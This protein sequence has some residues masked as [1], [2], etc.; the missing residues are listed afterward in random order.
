MEFITTVDTFTYPMNRLPHFRDQIDKMRELAE[1]YNF[2]NLPV[3]L[4]FLGDERSGLR[5]RV[6]CTDPNT[7]DRIEYVLRQ[8]KQQNSVLV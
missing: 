1:V 4:F 8:Y 6:D 3:K 7:K 5:Y 2:D